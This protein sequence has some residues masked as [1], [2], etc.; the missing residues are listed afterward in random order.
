M[1]PQ[2]RTPI[3]SKVVEARTCGVCGGPFTPRF[4][5]QQTCGGRCSRS[6]NGSSPNSLAAL[7]RAAIGRRAKAKRQ[8]EAKCH[9]RWPEMSVRDIEIFNYAVKLGYNRG[10]S[11]GLVHRRR[12]Q[13][14][15]I[16]AAPRMDGS[17][18]EVVAS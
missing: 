5:E 18:P 4:V 12:E 13:R 10:Y 2:A 11:R 17:A 16:Q 6:L 15:A 9:A 8:I 14:Q 3:R 1:A 7:Q